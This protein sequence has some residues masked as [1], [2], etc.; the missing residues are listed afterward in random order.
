MNNIITEMNKNYNENFIN[1]QLIQ[2]GCDNNTYLLENKDNNK[3]IARISNRN[4]TEKSLND[5]LFETEV[6]NYLSSNGLPIPKIINTRD[7]KSYSCIDGKITVVSKFIEGKKISLDYQNKPNLEIVK[8]AGIAL[9][10]L[11]NLTANIKTKFKN[12]RNIF[13]EIEKLLEKKA[14]LEKYFL[15]Y[16]EIIENCEKYLDFAKKNFKIDGIIH[17]DFRAQNLLTNK[18]NEVVAI[19]DF[20]WSC[21]GNFIKDLALAVVEWSFPDKTKS[22][23]SDVFD[24]FLNSYLKERNVDIDKQE[25]K[26]WI[27]FNCLSDTCTYISFLIEKMDIE[28]YQK[29][30]EI[31]S[32]MFQKFKFFGGIQ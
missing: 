11:H 24:T 16:T 20:D 30:K 2:E 15:N 14:D 27:C 28:N 31:K 22:Y 19:L 12:S 7:K 17:N 10:K 9:A 18:K 13:V 21:Y 1:I 8:N 23:W 5:F 6:L 26:N 3:F 4:E 29:K 32:F 25:L